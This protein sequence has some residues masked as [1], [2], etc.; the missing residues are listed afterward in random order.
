MTSD[1]SELKHIPNSIEYLATNLK[2][3]S[4][5]LFLGAGTS[6]GFGLPDWVG[7]VNSMRKEVN[8]PLLSSSSS[9]EELQNA[10][11]EVADELKNNGNLVDLTEKYLYENIQSLPLIKVFENKILLSISALLMGSKRGHVTRVVTLNYDSMIEW[12]L[13][14]FGF[15]VKTIYELPALEGSEDVRIYHPHGYIPHPDLNANRSDFVILGMDEVNKRLGTVGHPWFEMTRHILDSG[16]CLFLGMSERTLSDRA[17]APLFT[18]SGQKHNGIR[19]LGVWILKNPI[20]TSKEKE[21]A[22][23]NIIPITITDEQEICNFLLQICQKA[24]T[25]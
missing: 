12:F 23:N 8:L 15:M 25:I 21:F 10:A 14:L 2:D 22:R 7:L 11:D 5:V 20:S 4:L 19:P 18:T 16:V 9:A 13:S 3:G 6:K 24:M 1:F 17:L